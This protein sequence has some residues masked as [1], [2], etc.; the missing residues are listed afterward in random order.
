MNT[1]YLKFIPAAMLMLCTGIFSGKAQ[2][3]APPTPGGL[4]LSSGG[5]TT[6]IWVDGDHCGENIMGSPLSGWFGPTIEATLLTPGNPSYTTYGL[7]QGST[8]APV[9]RNSRFNFHKEMFF[10]NIAS[11]KLYS[12]APY[13]LTN[14]AAY[15]I[16]VV[17]DASQIAV[18][19]GTLLMFSNARTDGAAASLR[20]SN[21]SASVLNSYW[22]TTLRNPAF[23]PSANPRYGIATMNF[24]NT[25]N[26]PFDMYLNGTK[27]AAITLTGTPPVAPAAGWY[28]V[29]G[30]GNPQTAAQ[31]AA[32]FNGS[33]QEIIVMRKASG[34]MSN[35]DLLKVHSYLAIKYGITLTGNVYRNSK[36]GTVGPPSGYTSNVFGLARDDASG[37]NQKQAQSAND[38]TLTVFM[39][40]TLYPLNAQNPS[41]LPN[42][43][44]VMFGSTPPVPAN[45]SVYK[46]YPRPAGSTIG[47]SGQIS[48]KINYIS[49]VVYAV[50]ITELAEDGYTTVPGIRQTVGIKVNTPLDVR[51]VFVSK[52]A[53]FSEGSDIRVYPVNPNTGIT[54]G[55][56]IDDGD[57]IAYAGFLA[58]PGGIDMANYNLDLWIDGNHSSSMAW[59]NLLPANYQ[60]GPALTAAI[61]S[62]R[63]SR[64]NYQRELNFASPASSKLRTTTTY[65]LTT[66]NAYAIFAVS[67]ATGISAV[68][69]IFT[70]NAYASTSLRWNTGTTN[71]LYPYWRSDARNPNFAIPPNTRYGISTMNLVNAN[72]GSL[73]MYLNGNR[74]QQANLT[75]NAATYNNYFV[76]GSSTNGTSTNNAYPLKGSVQELI[77]MSRPAGTKMPDND[78]AK[79][80]SYLAVKYGLAL[81]TSLFGGD[82]LNS[83]YGTTAPVSD[84]SDPNYPNW[85]VIWSITKNGGFNNNIFGI[86]RDDAFGLWQK[87]S[88]SVTNSG[89]IAY[90]GNLATLNSDNTDE[91]L[92]D[93]QFLM[94]GSNAETPVM[95]IPAEGEGSIDTNAEYENGSFDP[96]LVTAGINIRSRD[97]KAQLT[98]LSKINVNLVAPSIDF[99]YVLVSMYPGFPSGT[100]GTKIYPV[101]QDENHVAQVEIDQNYRYIRFIGFAPG[102]GGVSPGLSLWLR[103]DDIGSIE[104]TPISSQDSRMSGYDARKFN[105]L[106]D[107]ANLPAVS[108]WHDYIRGQNYTYADAHG[109]NSDTYHRYPILSNSSPE[110][111]Y[112]PAVRFWGGGDTGSA[113]FLGN[114]KGILGTAHPDHTAI[115]MVN[116]DFTAGN[117]VYQMMFADSPSNID[118][119]GP[120]YGVQKAST[121]NLVGRVRTSQSEVSGTLNLFK[122]GATSIMGYYLSSN[123]A[124]FRFS[125]MID[126]AIIGNWGS[127]NMAGPSQIGK[128]YNTT[129][130]VVGVMG[131][132]IIFDRLLSDVE[133][134]KVESYLALKY[135]VTHRPGGGLFDYLFSDS[136]EIWPAASRGGLYDAYYNNVAAVVRDDRSRLN[137]RHAHSTDAGS[138]LHVG[139]AGSVL[140]ADGSEVG[141]LENMEAV[142]FGCTADTTL[143]GPLPLNNCGDFSERFDRIWLI[144]KVANR[145]ITLL[146]GAQNNS[147]ITLGQVTGMQ[148]Y[149]SRLTADYDVTM[150]VATT[151]DSLRQGK[152]QAAIPMELVNGEYQ[153]SY[154]FTNENTYITFG[155]V[156][157]NKGCA[158]DVD[159]MFGGTKTF[160]WT[161]WTRTTGAPASV[162]TPE[163][164]I[165]AT[166]LINDL[167]DN[168]IVNSQTYYPNGIGSLRRYPRSVNVRNVNMGNGSLQVQRRSRFTSEV[169]TT[170]GFSHPVIPNF[171]ISAL[172]GAG[173]S[174]EKVTISGVCHGAEYNP[175]LNY[176]APNP[177]TSRY[178]ITGNA[179]TIKQTG[180]VSATNVNG[181]VNVE[182]RGAVDTVQVAYTVTNR[183]NNNTRSIYI[184]PIKITSPQPPPPVNEAG[185]SFSKRANNYDVSTCETSEVTYTYEIRNTNC[186]AITVNQFSDTLPQYLSWKAGSIILPDSVIAK[187]LNPNFNPQIQGANNEILFI[188]PLVVPPGRVLQIRATA[189]LADEIQTGAYGNRA[190]FTYQ[191]L[192]DGISVSQKQQSSD[193]FYSN[194]GQRETVIQVVKGEPAA[195]IGVTDTY[196]TP[197]YT[198]GKEIEVTYTFNNPNDS[199]Q[200]MYLDIFY[201]PEFTYKAGSMQ[202]TT[203]IDTTGTMPSTYPKVYVDTDNG[204]PTGTLNVAGYYSL[205]DG[206]TLPPGETTI[207]FV[208]V[209]PATKAAL[210]PNYDENG[211]AIPGSITDLFINYELNSMIDDACLL[212]ALPGD[213]FK[214]IP[215][216]AKKT[217]I[218]TNKNVTTKLKD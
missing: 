150:V 106:D 156:P 128:G 79:V 25:T 69:T 89:L 187:P 185:L 214:V 99:V 165:P 140:S 175:Q 13:P 206:F 60:L 117:W 182:F 57:F 77:V 199:I 67:D 162:S 17:S 64:F 157:T 160:L 80:H 183:T 45:Q 184:S 90:L 192:R 61:P 202:I 129:R 204:V 180:S 191:L 139:V 12:S 14:G 109:S 23:S 78:V 38:S 75:V 111:N 147:D 95:G 153:C 22:N 40:N 82:Y 155:C 113:S 62:V 215:Y 216:S 98:N 50:R 195:L 16:F 39:G 194:T 198:E 124:K 105:P 123:N 152:Y 20:W 146:I 125:G 83:D 177:A 121:G 59:P 58:T 119:N 65:P 205:D 42:M 101:S 169:V 167:G 170:I 209:A 94:I 158:A 93:K 188:D 161:S 18:E 142:A 135:G 122:P 15:Q 159:G 143:T 44:Y 168:I 26:T 181:M 81:G 126:N 110:M 149:Y 166:P 164:W 55:V 28:L 131:E 108:E 8:Y 41:V 145:P 88:H 211:V 2:T 46:T 27:G 107:P 120:G 31:S 86:G 37:L 178:T 33:I 193:Y 114:T 48:E 190:A 96:K 34:Q 127:A 103:A 52:D 47:T 21:A 36:G 201:N 87:Q 7:G 172:D 63:N 19:N 66:G 29:V 56:Q 53:S 1:N 132:A 76:L 189:V 118:Y 9:V 208:L 200:Q 171:T 112:Y 148:A 97:Y 133:T 6:D 203:D 196:S 104:T 51:Y 213:G 210:I 43:Q 11:S 100:E 163:R 179:A 35:D 174:Y 137:N 73:D 136:T 4:N 176:V 84:G 85:G 173:S 138:L 92:Q 212:Q 218:I 154:E 32:P 134:Q 141:S 151:A 54:T 30:N 71:I 116:N 144:H 49:K 70:F 217:N 74:N 72:G 197:S 115:F 207:T 186:E 5:Y 102:P 68:S 130:G 3:L 91:T 10:G 24:V